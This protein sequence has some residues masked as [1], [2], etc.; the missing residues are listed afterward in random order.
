MEDRLAVPFAD[1]PI[2]KPTYI[3]ELFDTIAP[4]YDRMNLLMTW[5]QWRYWQWQ[6]GRRLKAIGVEG[7]RALDVACGTGD[8]TALLARLVGPKG[9]VTGLDFSAG[10]L[11]VARRRLERSGLAARVE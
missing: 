5:G 11:A 7:S 10:M 6:L 8:M 2:D 4:G 9:H 1:K 3:R